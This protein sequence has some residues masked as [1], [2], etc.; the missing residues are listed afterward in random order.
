MRASA[1][2]LPAPNNRYGKRKEGI[3]EFS[4]CSRKEKGKGLGF[5]FRMWTLPV[6]A[7]TNAHSFFSRI[8]DGSVS[9]GKGMSRGKSWLLEEEEE[10]E[11]RLLACWDWYV[12]K[13]GNS[14]WNYFSSLE[15]MGSS[16][17][18]CFFHV[19]CQVLQELFHTHHWNKKCIEF[20][21]HLQ[22]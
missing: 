6:L 13:D 3:R 12:G 22:V 17:V 19:Q 7:A 16:I 5:F 2:V 15:I 11:A 21:A 14:G 18:D 1:P 9:R 20:P 10:E 8:C 4:H